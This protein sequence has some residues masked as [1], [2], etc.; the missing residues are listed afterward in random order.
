MAHKKSLEALD[1]TL[2]DM[3]SNSIVFGGALILLAG[4]FRRTLPVIP[5][6]TPADELNACL[7]SSYLWQ[8]VH[9]L[10][11]TTKQ[12]LDLGNGK[13]TIEPTTNCVKF[14]SNFCRITQSKKELIYCVFPNLQRNFKNRQWLCERALLAPKNID[15]N[16]INNII[17][18]RIDGNL[19]TYKS[20][21]TVTNNDDV[22]NVSP[23][24]EVENWRSNY[25]IA[26]Y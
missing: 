17:L 14:P 9:T 26:K 1:R 24:I 20:I 2:K 12:L 7:K 10:K 6:S 15:V 13:M 11:L 18:N 19:K 3:R 16:C 5:G 25:F 21:D 22:V 23:R 4:D 8:H